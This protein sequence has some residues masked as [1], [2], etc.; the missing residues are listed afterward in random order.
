MLR[1]SENRANIQK[2]IPS[3]NLNNRNNFF[4]DY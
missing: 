4:V 1:N 3:Q 2:A